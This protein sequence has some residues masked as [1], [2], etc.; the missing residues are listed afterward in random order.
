[1]FF[2]AALQ[3]SGISHAMTFT[4]TRTRQ[5]PFFTLYSLKQKVAWSV[6]LR[7]PWFPQTRE[8]A[9]ISEFRHLPSTLSPGCDKGTSGCGAAQ[10]GATGLLTSKALPLSPAS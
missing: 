3:S 9:M 1:M 5:D 2:Q 6:P 8:G 4:N 10:R 7:S